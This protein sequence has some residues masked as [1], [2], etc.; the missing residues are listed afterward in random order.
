MNAM[1]TAT[2][3]VNKTVSAAFFERLNEGVLDGSEDWAAYC[4]RG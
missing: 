3:A 4:R 2:I 1:S